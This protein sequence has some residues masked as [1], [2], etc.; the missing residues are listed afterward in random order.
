MKNIH[1]TT[2]KQEW[3]KEHKNDKIKTQ[4]HYAKMGLITPEMEYV[5]NVENLTSELVRSEAERGRLIIPANINH[6]NLKPM[7]IGVATR[8]KINSN[9][10][11]SSLASCIEE[12]VEKVMVSIEYGADTIM[13]LS[14]GGNLNEIRDA[15]INASSVPIGTVPIY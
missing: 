14:T 12:E 4:L 2:S 9:I 6:E 11:S 3:E 5:A 13:D 8:T 10:G 7:G 15:V 1:K